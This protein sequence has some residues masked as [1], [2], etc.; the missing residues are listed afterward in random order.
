ME[1]ADVIRAGLRTK[2]YTHTCIDAPG[3]PVWRQARLGGIR[4]RLCDLALKLEVLLLLA[5][6]L[7][8]CQNT[9]TR[10]ITQKQVYL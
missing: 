7:K 1:F 2:T 5:P 10:A 6:D 4:G 3:S 8:S 9:L